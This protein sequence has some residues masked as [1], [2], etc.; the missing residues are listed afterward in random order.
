METV[1]I[2]PVVKNVAEEKNVGILGGRGLRVEETVRDKADAAS[3]FCG[4][5]CVCG[6]FEGWGVL[7]DDL[8][9]R[10]GFGQC[11][12]DKTIG[13]SNLKRIL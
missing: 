4:D 3:E 5:V 2:G 9:G 1:L 13:A 6:S 10:E 8:E 12:A 7:N 11:D